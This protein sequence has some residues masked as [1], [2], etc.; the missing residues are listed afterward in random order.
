MKLPTQSLAV[1][2]GVSTAVTGIGVRESVSTTCL[3]GCV[4]GSTSCL[5]CGTDVS[6]WL[7]CGG[8]SAACCIAGCF[9]T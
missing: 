4:A 7:T 5:K 9:I 1:H 2:R 3:L 8:L 6:C